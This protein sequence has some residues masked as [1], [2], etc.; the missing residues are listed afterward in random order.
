MNIN[1]LFYCYDVP[2][3]LEAAIIGMNECQYCQN[4]HTHACARE[5]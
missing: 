4:T 5:K 1:T 2:V 3:L